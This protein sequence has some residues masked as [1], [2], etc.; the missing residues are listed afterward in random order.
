MRVF[1]YFAAS[2]AY[3]MFGKSI[4]ILEP[5][6]VRQVHMKYQYSSFFVL[7]PVFRDKNNRIEKIILLSS[8]SIERQ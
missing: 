6:L 2:A 3:L 1:L 7:E 5:D 8:F 4:A